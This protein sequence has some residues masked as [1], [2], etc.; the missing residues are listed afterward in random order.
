MLTMY[1][2]YFEQSYEAIYCQLVPEELYCYWFVD[3][4]DAV[5]ADG[6]AVVIDTGQCCN[7]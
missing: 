1:C 6:Y 4:A 5:A 2:L 3:G 7:S